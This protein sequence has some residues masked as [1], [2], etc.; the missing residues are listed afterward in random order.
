MATSFTNGEVIKNA[1]VTP[2]GIPPCTNPINNGTDE[3]EQNG[4]TTPNKLAIKYSNQIIYCA[5]SN[6][7]PGRLGNNYLQR[8]LTK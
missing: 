1:N 8:P 3:Q 2:K 5:T 4:V 6:Y 7:V